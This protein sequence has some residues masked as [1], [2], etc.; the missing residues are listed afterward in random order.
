MTTETVGA[1]ASEAGN[2]ADAPRTTTSLEPAANAADVPDSWVALM[3]LTARIYDTT[4]VPR[5]LRGNP[6]EVLAAMLTGQELGLGP[7]QSLRMINVIEGRPSISAELMRALVNRA[8]HRLSVVEAR[9]DKVTLFGQRRDTGS[10]ATVTWTL[11]DAERAR[12]TGNP[13]WAKYPRSMLL[14]RATSELCR[15]IFADIVTGLYTPEEAA[16]IEGQVWE[17]D[18]GPCSSTR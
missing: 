17:P 4:F 13:A 3:R 5:T 16:A 6:N 2:N 12:L 18:D 10:S 1:S 14:A 15:Q 9:Q 11:K 7:M 8:G